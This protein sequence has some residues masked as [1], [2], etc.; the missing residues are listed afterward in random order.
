MDEAC[1]NVRVQLDSKPEVLDQLD[2]KIQRRA[3]AALSECQTVSA[4]RVRPCHCGMFGPASG[5][6]DG[7]VTTARFINASISV[8]QSN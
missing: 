4:R 8:T 3:K 6:L 2:R 7:H 5:S 1:A